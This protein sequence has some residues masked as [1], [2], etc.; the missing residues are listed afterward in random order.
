[1]DR[2]ANGGLCCTYVRLIEKTG[3]SVDIQAI[4]NH[5]VNNVPIFTAGAVVHIERGPVII[6][7]HQYAYIGHGKTIHSS[8]QLESFNCDINDKCIK[9]NGGLHCITTQAGF[10]ITLDIISGLPYVNLRPYT[11]KEWRTLPHVI[12]TSDFTWDP[13]ILNNIISEGER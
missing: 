10:A 6:I 9:V 3:R 1:M 13:T 5:Q 12:L 7:F 2:G 8:G 4:D 11:D